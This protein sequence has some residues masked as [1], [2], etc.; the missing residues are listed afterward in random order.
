MPDDVAAQLGDE[1]HIKT[2]HRRARP[3]APPP[4]TP[5]IRDIVLRA[6]RL[7]GPTTV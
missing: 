5:D 1:W 4:D 2:H 3:A 7:E 6:H